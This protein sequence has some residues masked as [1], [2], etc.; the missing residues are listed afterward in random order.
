MKPTSERFFKQWVTRDSWH[1][2]HPSENLFFY[3][4]ID[5]YVKEHGYELDE[6]SL[7]EQILSSLDR[8]EDEYY[9][10]LTCERV[11]FMKNLLEYLQ[12]IKNP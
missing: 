1:E 12:F 8:R 7:R 2:G 3:R 11:S 10:K 6:A 9:Q 5:A 4:F